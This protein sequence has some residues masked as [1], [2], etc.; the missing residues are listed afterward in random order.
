MFIA[1]N[2]FKVAPGSEEAFETVW[3]GRKSRLDTVPGFVE[4]HLLRGPATETHT[5]RLAH[6]VGGR[7]LVPR[8]D[9]LGAVPRRPP[10]R[11]WRRAA[12]SRPPEFEG[13]TS[14]PGA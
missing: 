1:M 13:F 8:L 11:R 2:R 7:G 5:L 14:V 6:R 4:F 12:L 9:H 3:R 10:R